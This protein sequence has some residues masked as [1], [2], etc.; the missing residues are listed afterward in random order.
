MNMCCGVHSR[1]HTLP[2]IAAA[3]R[4]ADPSLPIIRLRNMDDVFRASV[5]RPRMLM[6][7]LAGFAGLALL[8]AAIGTCRGLRRRH[9]QSDSCRSRHARR[10]DRGP[11]GGAAEN[12]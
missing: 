2:S 6:Q 3:V 5:R 11:E 8:L 12:G 7:L 9:R 1:R 4:E 10:S